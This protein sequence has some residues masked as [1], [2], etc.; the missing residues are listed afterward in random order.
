M[1]LKRF[2]IFLSILLGICLVILG[3]DLYWMWIPFLAHTQEYP[4]KLSA[5]FMAVSAF[6]TL[7]LALAAVRTIEESNAREQ[8]V[9]NRS[10]LNEIIQ[11]A[12]D[13]TVYPS[14]VITESVP[15]LASMEA[16]Q[17]KAVVELLQRTNSRNLWLRY[18]A[19]TGRRERVKVI[20]EDFKKSGI[21]KQVNLVSDKLD[22]VMD[23]LRKHSL[24]QAS[25]NDVQQ[26][27]DD[28]HKYADK[29]VSEASKIKI[30]SKE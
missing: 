16:P 25:V 14:E 6:I 20:A 10:A 24:G 21:A 22:A 18:N 1:T 5:L 11:W 3:T 9:I 19:L 13:I 15:D 12:I 8:R 30:E 29:L 4:I 17:Q 28:L 23:L 27:G 2:I 26:A 7:L